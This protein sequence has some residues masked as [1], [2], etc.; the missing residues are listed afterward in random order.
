MPTY[1][2]LIRGINVGGHKT[3]KMEELRKAVEK[4]GCERVRTYVQ[5]GNIVF[6]AAKHSPAALS[7]KIEAV[8]LKKFGHEVSVITKTPED[9]EAAIR[10]NPFLKEKAIDISKLHV[11]FLSGRPEASALKKLEGFPCGD[12]KF[13]CQGDIIYLFCANGMGQTK[14]TN[15]ALEKLLSVRATARNWRSVNNLHQMALDQG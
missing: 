14:L 12:D 2:S 4:L 6:R 3:V 11:A 1:I 10:D 5:S 7:R 13:H 8:I 9:F 15:T